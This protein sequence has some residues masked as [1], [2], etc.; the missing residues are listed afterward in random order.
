MTDQRTA[1]PNNEKVI[2]INGAY[3]LLLP[4]TVIYLLSKNIKN[5]KC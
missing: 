2:I 4:N 5:R 3:E 1:H